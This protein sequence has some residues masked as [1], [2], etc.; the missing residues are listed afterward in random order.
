VGREPGLAFSPDGNLLASTPEGNTVFLW[1]SAT[2]A[3]VRTLPTDRPAAVHCLAFR[4]DGREV[5]AAAGDGSVLL[6]DAETA[7]VT[8]AVMLPSAG[9]AI[10][11]VAYSPDGR[12]LAV[13]HNGLVSILRQ[14]PAPVRKP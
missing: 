11:Q 12:H 4:P 5:A 7:E 14:A 1:E 2:G 13:G 6:W 3:Q 9:S 10:V 8:D